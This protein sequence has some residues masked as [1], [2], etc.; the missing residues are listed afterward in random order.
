MSPPKNTQVNLLLNVWGMNPVVVIFFFF[1]FF[2]FFLL[3]FF[4]FFFWGGG[5]S[6]VYNTVA[7]SVQVPAVLLLIN[8]K[9]ILLFVQ[10]SDEKVKSTFDWSI[11][12]QVGISLHSWYIALHYIH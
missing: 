2:F 1:F 9:R 5:V 10:L 3:F 7:T 6:I 12:M 8:Q 11:A 4:F